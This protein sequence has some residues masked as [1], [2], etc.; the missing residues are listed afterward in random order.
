MKD[1]DFNK[2]LRHDN[3]ASSEKQWYRVSL[4]FVI[5][6]VIALAIIHGITFMQVAALKQKKNNFSSVQT[7]LEYARHTYERLK[8]GHTMEIAEMISCIAR[9]IPDD[10]RLE[11]VVFEAQKHTTL[12]GLA[13]S[14]KAFTLFVNRLQHEGC[15]EKSALH[16]IS[17]VGKGDKFAFTIIIKPT[18]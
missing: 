14:I 4:I 16:S 13:R 15:F 3:R 2:R 9:I 10:V 12:S 1:T 8:N 7:Q 6:T 17:K 5:I 18:A 11:S